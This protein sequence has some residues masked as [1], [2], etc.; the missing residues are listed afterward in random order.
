RE[1]LRQLERLE[2]D[3][4]RGSFDRLHIAGRHAELLRG[5]GR[6]NDAINLL[7]PA[8]KEYQDANGGKLPASADWV[9]SNLV[10][11]LKEAGHYAEG[12]R[13]LLDLLVHPIHQEHTFWVMRRLYLHYEHT[14]VG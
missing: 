2:R 8:L 11:Y 1:Q 9:V 7:Q 6:I 12:E 13:I 5:Y 10:L 14:L 3:A 4:A